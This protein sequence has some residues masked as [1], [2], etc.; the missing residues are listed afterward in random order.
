M[1]AL[2]VPNIRLCFNPVHIFPGLPLLENRDHKEITFSPASI[3]HS[4]EEDTSAERTKQEYWTISVPRSQEKDVHN[5]HIPTSLPVSANVLLDLQKVAVTTGY[6]PEDASMGTSVRGGYLQGM[7]Q[8]GD[9]E[10]DSSGYG[11]VV[12]PA[13]SLLSSEHKRNKPHIDEASG[14]YD[15]SSRESHIRIMSFGEELPGPAFEDHQNLPENAGGETEPETLHFVNQEETVSL[16]NIAGKDTVLKQSSQHSE[17]ASELR[18]QEAVTLSPKDVISPTPGN[19]YSEE[20]QFLPEKTEAWLVPDRNQDNMET[21]RSNKGILG[22]PDGSTFTEVLDLSEAQGSWEVATQSMEN[23]L[24]SSTIEPSLRESPEED[25]GGSHWPDGATA[26]PPAHNPTI[27]F[28]SAQSL[29]GEAKKGAETTALS[30]PEVRTPFPLHSTSEFIQLP[31]P[32]TFDNPLVVPSSQPSID[33][34]EGEVEAKMDLEGYIPSDPG[35]FLPMETNSGSGEE[36]EDVPRLKG[37]PRL[38]WAQE[39]NDS[40]LGKNLSPFPV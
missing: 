29:P 17:E 24:E 13:E 14:E 5:E 20:A 25:N 4:L 33:P 26:R 21:T 30:L 38:V 18:G 15:Y 40:L 37:I 6:D 34:I 9:H 28:S 11:Q 12:T 3:P 19:V 35:D 36:K 39:M 16:L 8:A 1:E 7:T 22:P 10:D 23:H 31:Q 32:S 2:Y 27:F